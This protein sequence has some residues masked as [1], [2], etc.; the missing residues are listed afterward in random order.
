MFL[1]P[2]GIS[3]GFLLALC[4]QQGTE[5]EKNEENYKQNKINK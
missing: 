5:R 3:K 4:F 2:L 1:F